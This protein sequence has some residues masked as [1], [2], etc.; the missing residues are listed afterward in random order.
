MLRRNRYINKLLYSPTPHWLPIR[1]PMVLRHFLAPRPSG[2]LSHLGLPA[3][4]EAPYAFL[5]FVACKLC[6]AVMPGVAFSSRNFCSSLNSQL[7]FYLLRTSPTCQVKQH[8]LS[9]VTWW[10]C[11]HC[12]HF[13]SGDC[14]LCY[15]PR[16]GSRYF[17]FVRVCSALYSD[18]QK[19]SR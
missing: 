17:I 6:M 1:P 12:H 5:N 16:T 9:L 4:L 2:Q 15:A 10:H 11:Y 14:L 13:E 18:W 3:D 8:H 19:H 7:S